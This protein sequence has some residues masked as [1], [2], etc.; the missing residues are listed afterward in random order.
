[1]STTEHPYPSTPLP[2]PAG[3]LAHCTFSSANTS[4]MSP[5]TRY[6]FAMLDAHDQGASWPQ[7]HRL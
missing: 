2:S 6:E 1:M 3:P 7:L 4:S 5:V